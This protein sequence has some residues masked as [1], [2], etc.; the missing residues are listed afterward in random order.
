MTWLTY[1]QFR[2]LHADPAH[3]VRLLPVLKLGP[4]VFVIVRR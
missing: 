1:G 2:R 3:R 4:I